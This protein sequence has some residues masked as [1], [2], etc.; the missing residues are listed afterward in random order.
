MQRAQTSF[1]YCMS[2]V[3]EYAFSTYIYLFRPKTTSPLD[4]PRWAHPR[5][6]YFNCVLYIFLQV[7]KR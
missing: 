6:F 7:C 2:E 5:S 3:L 1:E 4:L